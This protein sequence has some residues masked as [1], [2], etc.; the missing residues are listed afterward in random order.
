MGT[1]LVERLLSSGHEVIVVDVQWF[2]NNLKTNE[3]L[4]VYRMDIRD[5][6]NQL[7]DGIEVV[8]HLANIAND[9]GVDLNPVLSWEINVLANM[10]LVEQAITCGARKFIYAS[11][12]SVYGIKTEEHVTEDLP[13]EPISVYNKTKMVAERVLLSYLN[14]IEIYCI[15]PATVC[16]WS[17]RMR[18]DL[19]VNMLTLQALRD[20]K[21]TVF[22]GDQYR[23]NVNILDLVRIYQFFIENADID[24]GIYNAGFENMSISSIAREISSKVECDI[25]TTKSNDPRSYRLDSNKLVKAGFSPKY[26]IGDAI[27]EIIVLYQSG[28]LVDTDSCYNVRWMKELGL[29]H[30]S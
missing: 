19:S 3:K 15:R 5:I 20:G 8:V 26:G 6:D 27:D 7:I 4:T 21:I 16:G 29:D 25:V 30:S 22:G 2:G 17:P 12:G 9:P 14:E 24:T 11:S 1:M 10:R 28:E 18:L 23:P 13:L